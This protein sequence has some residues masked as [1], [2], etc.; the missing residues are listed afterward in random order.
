MKD[1][2][3]LYKEKK[4]CT[5]CCACMNICPKGAIDMVEDS[6]GFLYPEVNDALC[7]RCGKCLGVCA[8]A[9]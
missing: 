6:E 7:I 4:D 8:C 1:I 2:P 9:K 3:V 5:G